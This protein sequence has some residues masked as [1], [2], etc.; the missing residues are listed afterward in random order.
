[1]IGYCY[2]IYFIIQQG[3]IIYAIYLQIDSILFFILYL[4]FDTFDISILI[5][6]VI[7]VLKDIIFIVN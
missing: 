6:I 4:V 3:I 2:G 5:I 7:T 1:M